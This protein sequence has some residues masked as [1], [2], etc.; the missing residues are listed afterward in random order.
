ML[1]AFFI[2]PLPSAIIF[3][4]VNSYHMMH[5]PDTIYI[6]VLFELFF[7]VIGYLAYGVINAVIIVPAGAGLR[8]ITTSRTVAFIS[9]IVIAVLVTFIAYYFGLLG[10][11]PTILHEAFVLGVFVP[12]CLSATASFLFLLKRRSTKG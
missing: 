4:I 11:K 7:F 9:A 1:K 5:R 12:V 8:Q 2:S 10:N 6:P 3:T